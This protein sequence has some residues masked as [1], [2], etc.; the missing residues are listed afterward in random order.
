MHTELGKTPSKT[1][2]KKERTTKENA[3]TREGDENALPRDYARAYFDPGQR[4]RETMKMKEHS[5]K[6]N[7]KRVQNSTKRA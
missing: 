5:R 1:N 2:N 3:S 6:S 7:H 4:G